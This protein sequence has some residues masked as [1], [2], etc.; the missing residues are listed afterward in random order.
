MDKS[1]YKPQPPSKVA[2]GV[3]TRQFPIVSVTSLMR[4]KARKEFRILVGW[5]NATEESH[6]KSKGLAL[7]LLHDSGV[8][9]A[10]RCAAYPAMHAGHRQ[11]GRLS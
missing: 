10:D 6:R 7:A 8:C 11:W 3:D 9:E 5:R 4:L 1:S 2:L